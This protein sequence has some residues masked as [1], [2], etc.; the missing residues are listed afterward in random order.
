MQ[1][2]VSQKSMSFLVETEWDALKF[3]LYSLP[4]CLLHCWYSSHKEYYISAVFVSQTHC[5]V[6][7]W[8]QH[9]YVQQPTRNLTLDTAYPFSFQFFHTTASF[10]LVRI[11][12]EILDPHLAALVI[13]FLTYSNRNN[14]KEWVV[15]PW[16]VLTASLTRYNIITI[17]RTRKA[18]LG[19]CGK[20]H[21][22]YTH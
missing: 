7:A 2:H 4:H 22:N 6:C 3:C 5:T 19:K 14:G 15:L 12:A 10:P 8:T 13:S 1:A 17:E 11:V 9:L 20:V 16:R 18:T 21:V